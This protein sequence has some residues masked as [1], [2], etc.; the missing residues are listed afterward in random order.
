M[1]RRFVD[2]DK[3]FY[4]EISEL[5]RDRLRIL[6]GSL[7]LVGRSK[8]FNLLIDNYTAI[9]EKKGRSR[10]SVI[11]GGAGMGKTR[12]LMDFKSYLSKHKI[13][14]ITTSFSRHENNLP[15]N[16]LANGFNE[17]L[18]RIYKSQQVEAEEIRRKVKTLLGPTAELVAK[19]VPGLKPYIAEDQVEPQIENQDEMDGQIDFT[20]L[21]RPFQ[22]SPDV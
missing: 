1:P 4:S 15:F 20:A 19:I 16:A 9:S 12:L 14:Y 22:T 10:L 2:S 13:R 5:G 3:D 7:D 21:P 8:E 11:R 18:I 17:Y 6:T